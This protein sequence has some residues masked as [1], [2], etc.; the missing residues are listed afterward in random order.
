M[1]VSV[2]IVGVRLERYGPVNFCD[3]SDIDL[4]VGDRVVVETE[5]G[6][7]EAEVVIAPGQVLYSAVRGTAGPVLRKIE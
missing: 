6:E 7:R 3:P 5:D 4:K 2:N 1:G